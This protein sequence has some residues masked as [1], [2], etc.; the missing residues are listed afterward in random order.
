[1]PAAD[2]I[3]SQA[4]KSQL[5]AALP[6]QCL[7]TVGWDICQSGTFAEFVDAAH[8]ALQL[9][10]H[11]EHL[12]EADEH[13]VVDV[14][15]LE[16]LLARDFPVAWIHLVLEGAP[17]VAVFLL[18]GDGRKFLAIIVGLLYEVVPTTL[19]VGRK[20]V[21]VKYCSIEA[22]VTRLGVLP[23]GHEVG[24]HRAGT[25]S[26]SE[27]EGVGISLTATHTEVQ[28]VAIGITDGGRP[29]SHL[30]ELHGK[31]RLGVDTIV[32][33]HPLQALALGVFVILHGAT[34][35]VS[36]EVA[37]VGN[38]RIARIVDTIVD[39]GDDLV[40]GQSGA[41]GQFN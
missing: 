19:G 41:I 8:I 24:S 13:H 17:V 23:V 36:P 4:L 37:E 12:G 26:L 28:G 3:E 1:M 25:P 38:Q 20:V 29:G 30:V 5:P 2:I 27:G 7:K 39:I 32:V 34:V 22:E 18:R 15:Q 21:Q 33:L 14:A 35:G 16:V 9:A 40:L 10:L 11:E 6:L 31:H